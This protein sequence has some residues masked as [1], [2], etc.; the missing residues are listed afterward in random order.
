MFREVLLL[1]IRGYYFVYTAIGIC[2]AFT[3]IGCWLDRESS[4]CW[5]WAV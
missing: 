1:I 2:H 3:L 4:T 5:W